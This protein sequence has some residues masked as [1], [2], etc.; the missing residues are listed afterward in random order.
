[1][2]NR[3]LIA[4]RDGAAGRV[5][6]DVVLDVRRLADDQLPPLGGGEMREGRDERALADG[7]V[8]GAGYGCESVLFDPSSGTRY[9]ARIGT[10]NGLA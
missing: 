7:D 10:L 1:V 3:D 2:G 8:D 4:D 5:D 6:C 9:S